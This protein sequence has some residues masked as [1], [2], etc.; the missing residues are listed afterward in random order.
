[1]QPSRRAA[2]AGILDRSLDAN[3]KQVSL[4]S[5]SFL[6]SEMVQYCRDRAEQLS[7]LE[8]KCAASFH[9]APAPPSI[10]THPPKQ[11]HARGC[12]RTASHA[13]ARHG[14][15]APA[16]PRVTA[17]AARHCQIGGA[18]LSSR[19]PFP[20]AVHVQVCPRAPHRQQHAVSCGARKGRM[21]GV[22]Q[23]CLSSVRGIAIIAMAERVFAKVA[24]E[25]RFAL[26]PVLQR[27]AWPSGDKGA[28]PPHNPKPAF[29]RV[30]PTRSARGT[31]PASL[32]WRETPGDY[33]HRSCREWIHAQ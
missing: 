1:M 9:H 31:P 3:S 15:C 17:S 14:S 8:N 13:P 26:P 10:H 30:R 6:F 24:A 18:R 27:Q 12:H 33:W 4:S 32:T 25:W 28:R 7:D 23:R 16:F 29:S 5:F 21:Q 19:Q 11:G 22:R 2:G 20:G